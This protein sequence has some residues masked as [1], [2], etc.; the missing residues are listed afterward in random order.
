[1]INALSY[2]EDLENAGF[3]P[4]QA[5]ATVSAWM[6]LMNA[7][8]ATNADLKDVEYSLKSSMKDL[9]RKIEKSNT[10]LLLSLGSLMI[11]M[12]GVTIG[13]LPYLIS[14]A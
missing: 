4:K 14:K 3:T 8:F 1:M 2:T 6:D 5:K 11:A 12:F 10:K 7:N 9:E 13:I